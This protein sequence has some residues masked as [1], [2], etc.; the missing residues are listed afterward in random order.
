M[1]F[2]TNQS[3]DLRSVIGKIQML[4]ALV[5]GNRFAHKAVKEQKTY[6]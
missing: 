5:Q 1:M 3:S 2:K 4:L 6:M